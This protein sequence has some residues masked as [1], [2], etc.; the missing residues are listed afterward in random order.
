MLSSKNTQAVINRDAELKKLEEEK[1]QKVAATQSEIDTLTRNARTEGDK[2]TKEARQSADDQLKQAK[3]EST[4]ILEKVEKIEQRVLEREEKIQLRLDEID[5]KQ[6]G[7]MK[8]EEEIKERKQQLDAKVAELDGKLSE[9]AKLTEVEA[10]EIFLKQIGLKYEKDGLTVIE[11]YKKKI[12]DE[13]KEIAR[14]I[15]LKSIQ[16]YA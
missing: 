12:E 4:A 2:V 11:K 9:I 16:Q 10:K 5:K 8:K 7:L 14:E 3:Q 13:K 1:A 15:V 6:D